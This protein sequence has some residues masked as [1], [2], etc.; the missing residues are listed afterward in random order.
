MIHH[1]SIEVSDLDRSADFY[2]AVLSPLGWRRHADSGQGVGWG[3]AKPV[4]F[5]LPSGDAEPGSGNVCF[6][7]TGIP[8]VKAAWEA[9]IRAGGNDDG[10]PGTR[11]QYGS[12]YYAANLLDPDGYRI[13]IAV[14]TD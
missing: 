10:R 2:D 6:A 12:G 4:F 5:V 7:A 3:I 8:A 13:E 14:G 1:V 11:A 9:G